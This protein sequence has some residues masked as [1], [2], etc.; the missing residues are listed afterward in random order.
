MNFESFSSDS[1]LTETPPTALPPLLQ[2]WQ[3]GD[4]EALDEIMPLV[5]DQF[6][7]LA[8]YLMEREKPGHTLQPTALVNEL[9]LHL[10]SRRQVRWHNTAQFIG[11]CSSTLRRLLI[12]YSR[13]KY[14]A[15]R[16]RN[17]TVSLDGVREPS[18]ERNDELLALH[19]ALRELEA[20][21]PR[22]GRIVELRF[23]LEL[24]EV[25]VAELL[26]L[27]TRTVRREWS[28]ARLWLKR[29][30]RS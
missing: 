11:Y 4:T 16:D 30:V 2:A 25:E 1:P 19:E 6:R 21:D 9:Y 28:A 20:L 23:L 14:A 13:R 22:Q 3:D 5:V 29:S 7:Q 17:K 18:G 24:T 26:G 15:K 8:R 27:S 12:D 10:R